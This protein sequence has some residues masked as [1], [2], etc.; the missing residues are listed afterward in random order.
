ISRQSFKREACIELIGMS[1]FPKLHSTKFSRCPPGF[2]I[3]HRVVAASLAKFMWMPEAVV[4]FIDAADEV[5]SI[6][7]P[8]ITPPVIATADAACVA[9]LPSP[10]EVLAADGVLITQAEP[11][12]AMKLSSV[13]FIAAI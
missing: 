5:R 2:T 9:M 7:V 11:V 10:S 12:P 1:I 3:L 8:L 6:L 4:M 13:G